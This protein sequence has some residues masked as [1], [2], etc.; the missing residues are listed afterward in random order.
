MT[1]AA[2]AVTLGNL[3]TT[4]SELGDHRKAQELQEEKAA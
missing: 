2:L 3:G 4:H 1:R